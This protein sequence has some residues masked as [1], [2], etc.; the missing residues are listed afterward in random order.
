M[1]YMFAECESLQK[2]NLNNFNTEN[3]KYMVGMFVWCGQLNEL[4]LKNFNINKVTNM[5]YMLVGCSEELKKKIKE[6]YKDISEKAF[7]T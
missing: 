7:D 1:S 6:R 3:V 5:V 2:I 4:N